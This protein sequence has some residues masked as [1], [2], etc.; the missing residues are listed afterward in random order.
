VK[1]RLN[2]NRFNNVHLLLLLYYHMN[3]LSIVRRRLSYSV[4]HF[5]DHMWDTSL[6]PGT[7]FGSIWRTGSYLDLESG[8]AF[9]G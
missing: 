3:N 5:S 9:Q 8:S 4:L 2:S 1:Y 6:L 7:K